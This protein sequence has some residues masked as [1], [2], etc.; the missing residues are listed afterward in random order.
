MMSAMDTG[1]DVHL[2]LDDAASGEQP[3]AVPDTVTFKNPF[4][5]FTDGSE[6]PDGFWE[7]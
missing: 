7:L 6:S 3:I 5:T 4:F 1:F 2:N